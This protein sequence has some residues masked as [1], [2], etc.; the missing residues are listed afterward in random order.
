MKIAR[1]LLLGACV[2]L[3]TSP[4][5]AQ[6]DTAKRDSAFRALPE[7]GA[8]HMGVDQ[9]TSV[10][11]LESLPDGGR[12]ELQRDP[13]DT[14]GVQRIRHHL[15]EIAEAFRRGDFKIPGLVHDNEEVPGTRAMAAHKADIYYV[16]RPLAGGGEIRI[17]SRDNDA[18]AAIH[19]FL[20]FQRREHHASQ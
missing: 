2:A 7:R 14:A 17:T 6:T 3:C 16:L 5:A 12:I 4:A 18:L 15:T 9:Y 11:H 19:E 10:H 20:A 1:L 8:K 13:Q